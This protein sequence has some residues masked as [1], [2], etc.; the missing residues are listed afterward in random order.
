MS[1]QQFMKLNGDCEFYPYDGGQDKDGFII[2]TPEGRQFKI[3]PLAKN[4]LEQLDGK[5]SLGQIAHNLN[6]DSVA[7]SEEQLHKLIETKYAALGIFDNHPLAQDGDGAAGPAGKPKKV[8]SSFLLHWNLIPQKYVAL[9]SERLTFLYHRLVASP[10]VL[11]IVAA[12]VIVYTRFTDT[13]FLSRAS[14]LNVLLLCLVSILGHEFGHAAAV[15]RYGGKPGSIGFA[16]YLLM[17]SFYADVSE[18]WRFPRRQRMVVDLGGVYFQQLIFATFALLGALYSAPEFFIACHLID[19]MALLTLNPIFQFDGYWL[20]VDYMAL[21]KL[22]LLAF[23]YL[24]Y[25]IKNMF[26]R[27]KE[28]IV[29]PPMRRHIYVSFLVYALL[30]NVFMIAVVWL[31]SRY[32]YS[33]FTRFPDLFMG[34][35]RSMT[36]AIKTQD[37]LLFINRLLTLFFVIAFPGTALIGL[38][39]YAIRLVQYC[40]SKFVA[41][42]APRT[43]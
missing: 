32:L 12:H 43:S 17:P 10:A 22:H 25:S 7:V 38:S 23:N 35:F 40:A 4:V 31:S 6:A 19:I 16:L 36:F 14:F 20:L 18:I 24:K 13:E 21:P 3:S 34:I 37:F 11:L 1:T 29:L 9:I 33:T 41:P 27:T 15:S 28:V 2:R 42:A 26:S 5:T 30:C 39:K 8:R